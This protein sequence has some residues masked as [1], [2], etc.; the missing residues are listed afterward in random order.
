MRHSD[1]RDY[2]TQETCFYAT[3]ID[4]WVYTAMTSNNRYSHHARRAISHAGILANRYHHPAVDTAHLLVGVLLTD[5]STGCTVLRELGLDARTTEVYLKN[6][7]PDSETAPDELPN[8]SALEEA[9]DL[10]VDEANWLGH[11]Y[12]GTEHFLL[13]ITRTNAGSGNR[14]LRLLD[15]SQGQVRRSV[16]RALSDGRMEFDL[17]N[18]KRDARLSEL[19]RRVVTAAEQMAVAM[20][21]P[22]VGL[23]HL[24]LVMANEKRSPVSR[25]LEKNGLDEAALRAS[26]NNKD[27]KLLL[28]VELTLRLAL[29]QA[30]K[31]GSHYTGTE[32]LLLVLTVEPAGMTLLRQY[33]IRNPEILR[34]RIEALLRGVR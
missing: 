25:L 22:T 30:E 27:T 34:A 17:Q 11:H 15:V 10:A 23:G 29:V 24:L 26:L 7:F 13:G 19:A 5:D 4:R 8:A 3:I 21:H 9:L 28:S 32:H 12:V 16:R 14:L 1:K 2:N 6:L 18:A 20:D 31:L 33:G